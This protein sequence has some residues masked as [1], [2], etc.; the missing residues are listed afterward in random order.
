MP[1]I[2]E[3]L[4]RVN[5]ARPDAIDDKTKAAWLIELDGK[6]FRDVILRHRLTSGRE[7]RG[8]IGVCPNCEATDGLKWDSAADSNA[9]P[10]CGWTDLPEVPKLFPEDGDKPLLVAAPDDILYD[11]YLMAQ[12]DFY[13]READNYNNSALA[14]NTALDE[15]KKEYHRSHA[16]I[17]AGYYTNVF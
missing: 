2:N 9:C 7:L 12:A 13:N 3:V 4:E 11:L 8:P 10:A 5:R 16:P 1:T 15:W 14:Y 6:L 17:G